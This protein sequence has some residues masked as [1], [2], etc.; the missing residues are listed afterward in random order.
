MDNESIFRMAIDLARSTVLHNK[1]E[2][3][4][5]VSELIRDYYTLIKEL[6]DKPTST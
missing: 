2:D 1:I 6:V 4:E 3:P 5:K